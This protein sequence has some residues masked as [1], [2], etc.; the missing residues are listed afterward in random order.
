MFHRIEI[1]EDIDDLNR[2]VY[3]FW[4]NG[5]DLYLDSMLVQSRLSKRARFRSDMDKSYSRVM[6]RNFG[7]REEPDI[8]ISVLANAVEKARSEIVFR[9]WRDL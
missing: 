9:K 7:L 3:N 2:V 8:E 1:V 5:V 4:L 6:N